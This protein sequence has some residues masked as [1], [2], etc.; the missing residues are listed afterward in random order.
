M[1]NI[2]AMVLRVMR[3]WVES[4]Q[5]TI[6][7]TVVRTWGSLPRPVGAVMALRGD[8]RVVGSVGLYGR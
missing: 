3:D 2:D 4:G 7:V 1:E 5:R 6:L 8:G